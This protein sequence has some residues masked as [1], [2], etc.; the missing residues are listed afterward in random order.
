MKMCGTTNSRSKRLRSLTLITLRRCRFGLLTCKRS[1]MTD[2]WKA[3]CEA[4]FEAQS[5]EEYVW[6]AVPAVPSLTDSRSFDPTA[7]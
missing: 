7:R 4:E 5:I 2:A 1:R 6:V 3:H